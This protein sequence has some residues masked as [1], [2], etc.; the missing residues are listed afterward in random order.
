MHMEVSMKKLSVIALLAMALLMVLVACGPQEPEAAFE[1]EDDAELVVWADEQRAPV[2]EELGAQFTE[3]YGVPV[4]VQ[5][6]G[7]GDIRDNIKVAGPAGEGADIIVGAHDWLGELVASGI[8][9]P[10]SLGDKVDEFTDASIQAFTYDGQ[11]YGMPYAVENVAFFYNPELVSSVP[12]TWDEVLELSREIQSAGTADYGFVRQEGDPYHFFPIQTAF[13]GYVFGQ[14][15]DGTYD[16][17]DVGIDAE[18]SIEAAEWLD[19]AV[20]DGVVPAGVDWDTYHSLFEGGQAAMIITGPWALDRLNA[21]GVSFEIANIP[22]GG[23]PFLGVQ[24]FMVSAFSENIPMAQAFLTEFVAQTDPM[25]RIYEIGGRPP[26]Y[27]PALAMVENEQLA[28]FGEAGV[29]GLPM[30]AIPEMSAVWTSWGDA[31]TLVM[32]EQ[33]EGESAFENAAQ[34]IR[35]LIAG[36]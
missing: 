31:V 18:G 17:T 30:P 16:P 12:A 11:L 14:N 35:S 3:T 1:I 34:Q 32:Q 29:V 2:M 6:L 33:A 7:F 13:G 19:T 27:E 20:T 21:S 15:P 23:Q 9:S 5:Q 26:A 4:T 22:G 28:A 25:F 24:G 8:V 36:E 10:I